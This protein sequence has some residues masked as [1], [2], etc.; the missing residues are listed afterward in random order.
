MT[1]SELLTKIRIPEQWYHHCDYDNLPILEDIF[2]GISGDI[3]ECDVKIS[4]NVY[5]HLKN[6]H[7]SHF[8]SIHS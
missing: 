1:K 5:Y 6:L 3:K 4:Y 8:P 7:N 2:D